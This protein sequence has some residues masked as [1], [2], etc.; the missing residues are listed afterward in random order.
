MTNSYKIKSRPNLFDLSIM[1]GVLNGGGISPAVEREAHWTEPTPED[2][3]T[4]MWM[5][6]PCT[7][8][9]DE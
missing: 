8:P 3:E 9:L 7:K 4:L 5:E 6:Y 2:M 1:E